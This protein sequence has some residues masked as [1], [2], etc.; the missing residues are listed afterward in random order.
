MP[1]DTVRLPYRR[2][3]LFGLVSGVGLFILFGVLWA[4][5]EIVAIWIIAFSA[6]VLFWALTSPRTLIPILRIFE[7]IG[8]KAGVVNNYVIL[9]LAYFLVVT[10][11]ALVLRIFRR[12]PTMNAPVEEVKSYFVPVRRKMNAQTMRDYF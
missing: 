6:A 1:Q 11:F 4:V 7:W 9:A 2:A 10:P 12:E 3:Q 8:R 5:F